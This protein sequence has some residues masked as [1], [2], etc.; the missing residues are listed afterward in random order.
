M[1]L[2]SSRKL[3]VES[4]ITHHFPIEEGAQAYE[5]I[6]GKKKEPFLG[7]L[8]TYS[9]KEEVK[10]RKIEFPN[11]VL[12]PQSSIKLGV[13]GAGLYAN[14][15]LLPVIKNNK[16]FELIGIASSGGLHAQHS[17]KKFGFQYATSSE[18]EIIN[19]PN[20]NTVAILTRHDS[21]ADLVVKALKAGKHVFVEKPLAINEQG[22][23]K[24]MQVLTEDRRPK[25]EKNGQ[26]STVHGLLTVGFNRRFSPLAQQLKSS[27]PF[28]HDVVNRKSSIFAHYRINAGY[29]PLNHWTQNPEQGGGRIIGE[30]C[31]FIDLIT[32]LV[33]APPISVTAHALPDGGK[34]REDNVSMTFTFPDGSLGV[35]DYL[36]NG[37][38]S[39]PK[40][41][42]EVFCE[43]K[44]AILDDYVKLEIIENGKRR[45]ENH[46][47]DK[48]WRN[49]MQ[50]FARAIREGGEPPIPYEQLI[51]V[52]KSTFAAI[53]S[54]RSKSTVSI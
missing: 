26:P 32:F 4:L 1:D 43:G 45:V 47:Q 38:K 20:I 39:F 40:E 24:V 48:G 33:G 27:I 12:H 37:D 7:V 10:S 34:Y 8:L 14:A 19:D 49:E 29:L 6:T 53:E 13:L 2:L 31:H 18:D 54:I 35:V 30:A 28:G 44:I 17:G 46:A 9:E 25:I 36:A 23:K 16:D 52:T 11:P 42:L 50:A 5:V 15:T 21:H 22:L 51:G 41:R 3:K